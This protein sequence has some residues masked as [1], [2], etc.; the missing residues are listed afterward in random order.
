MKEQKPK[1]KVSLILIALTLILAVAV[2]GFGTPGFLLGLISWHAPE[3]KLSARWDVDDGVAP[4]R[5]N[6]PAIEAEPLPGITVTAPENAFVS[7]RTIKVTRLSDSV[8]EAA[9]QLINGDDGILGNIIGGWDL[10]AGLA[11]GEL[12]LRNFSMSFNLA[13]LGVWEENYDRLAVFRRGE[14]GTFYQLATSVRDGIL[15]ALTR[16]NCPIFLALVGVL[17]WEGVQWAAWT[18]AV[19]V[20]ADAI[21]A[22]WDDIGSICDKLYVPVDKTTRFQIKFYHKDNHVETL[23][24]KKN[25]LFDAA[26]ATAKEKAETKARAEL[27]E[28]AFNALTADEKKLQ[29]EQFAVSIAEDEL[30]ADGSEFPRIC[31]ELSNAIAGVYSPDIVAETIRHAQTVFKYYESYLGADEMPSPIIELI[32]TPTLDH[33]VYAQTEGSFT[34]GNPYMKI[35]ANKDMKDSD[36]KDE[37]L[38]TIAHEYFHVLQRMER[39]RFL[40]SRKYDEGTAM[41]AE[42]RAYKYFKDNGKVSF[43]KDTF[44]DANGWEL[45]AMP[46]DFEGGEIIYGDEETTPEGGGFHRATPTVLDEGS[47]GTY[48][49]YATA[50]FI[51]FLC[52][53]K[54]EVSYKQMLDAYS[55]S[56]TD[57][58]ADFVKVVKKLFDLTDSEFD[59]YYRL[60]IRKNIGKIYGALPGGGSIIPEEE[61]KWPTA[62]SA[63]GKPDRKSNYPQHSNAGVVNHNYTARIRR[64]AADIPEDYNKTF[65]LLICKDKYFSERMPDM[66]LIPVG[67]KD[68]KQSK[69]GLFYSAQTRT[70]YDRFWIL[71]LDAGTAP[72]EEFTGASNYMVLTLIAPPE[73]EPKIVGSQIK[74]RM[75]EKST[76]A[77]YGKI[78]G[79]RVTITPSEG[80]PYVEYLKIASAGKERSINL[81]KIISKDKIARAQPGTDSDAEITFTVSICEY[82]NERDK[83]RT[84]GPE[85]NQSGGVEALLSEMGATDGKVAITLHWFGTDDLDL[86]CV[87]PDGSHIYYSNPSGGGGYLD[88]DMNISGDR[89]E[90]IE[91][92][93]FDQPKIGV[94][95]FYIVNYTDRTEGDVPADVTVTINNNEEGQNDPSKKSV[96]VSK[97]VSMGGRSPTWTF[98]IEITEDPE[99]GVEYVEGVPGETVAN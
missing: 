69:Y 75:P 11:E 9:Q 87:T 32:I 80:E 7:G 63:I 18:S 54:G 22:G 2:T 98:V 20:S 24:K 83:T 73:V 59:T 90:A 78:D 96:L 6:S 50:H 48:A 71:E 34:L 52:D 67:N 74:F 65:N 28:D 88:V 21:Y 58:R 77:I 17:V 31:S 84:F 51:N 41:V 12:A 8:M 72:A 62:G 42:M 45:Y 26:L 91:H 56:W 55:W 14:D 44:P 68:Y 95:Q 40:A 94:Y 43:T 81:S 27:G 13:E 3:T 93:Y 57:G 86:H 29:L 15:T 16:E 47:V 89:T 64:I 1:K 97:T 66:E 38:L 4:I 39:N 61:W 36:Q 5:G 79:Y 19:A 82:I 33:D 99:T 70:N 49:G 35:N 23:T 25:E 10:D 85:S 92:I 53:R 60:F 76:A 46:L 30:F 37:L